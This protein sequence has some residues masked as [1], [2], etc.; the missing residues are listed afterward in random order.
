LACAL[1]KSPKQQQNYYRAMKA[2][3]F[4]LMSSTAAVVAAGTKFPNA[5]LMDRLSSANYLRYAK[6]GGYLAAEPVATP[7]KMKIMR[8]DTVAK[9]IRYG[10]FTI[11][12]KSVSALTAVLSLTVSR[13]GR[14]PLF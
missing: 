10:P 1:A 5:Q 8:N 7:M 2:F 14:R 12:A 3:L 9:K 13:N 4:A 6:V 11:P